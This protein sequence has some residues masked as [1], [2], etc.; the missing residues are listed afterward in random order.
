MVEAKTFRLNLYQSLAIL[1][2]SVLSA[3]THYFSVSPSGNSVLSTVWVKTLDLGASVLVKWFDH[4]PGSGDYPGERVY[5]EEHLPIST[6]DTSNRIV[7]TK[8]HDK[9]YAEVIITGG[10]VELGIYAT[11]VSSFP[12]D[13][14]YLNG[15]DAN[16]A[17]DGGNANVIYNSADDKFYLVQGQTNGSMNVHVTGGVILEGVYTP[18]ILRG[19]AETTPNAWQELIV[20][21]P[22]ATK[23]WRLRKAVIAARCYGVWQVTAN[24]VIIGEGFTSPAENN[25]KY[26]FS[27]YW[28]VDSGL[29]VKVRF[30]QNYGPV[31]DVSAFMHL[32]EQDN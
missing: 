23:N 16:L 29:I 6:P 15:S 28:I 20:D 26:E 22:A 17:F 24:G 21:W 27:P 32:T 25:V 1:P 7:V 10:D 8:I 3:G 14:P 18:K 12:Q 5:L 4:G 19:N 13:P 2:V 11:S 9:A 30:K 31:C